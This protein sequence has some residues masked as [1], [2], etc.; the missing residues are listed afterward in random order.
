MDCSTPGPSVHGISQGGLLE[1]VA[2]SFSR[3][4]SRPRDRELMSLES[5]ALAGRFFYHW[6]TREAL[7]R[8]VVSKSEE[9]IFLGISASRNV[10]TFQVDST[11]ADWNYL[12]V[13]ADRKELEPWEGEAPPSFTCC[14]LPAFLPPSCISRHPHPISFSTGITFTKPSFSLDSSTKVILSI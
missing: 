12:L 9:E 7:E 10:S 8:V 2:I 6:A 14:H 5:S 11:A 13:G 3:G 1:W 4:S